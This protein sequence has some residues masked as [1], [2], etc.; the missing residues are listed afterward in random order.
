MMAN[1]HAITVGFDTN[2]AI[3]PGNKLWGNIRTRDAG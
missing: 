3:S 2:G 1:L